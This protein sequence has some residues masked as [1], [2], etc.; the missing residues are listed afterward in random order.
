MLQI[1]SRICNYDADDWDEDAFNALDTTDASLDEWFEYE[2]NG[3]STIKMN[4]AIDPG[5]TV[6]N[7]R[8][9]YPNELHDQIRTA[10]DIANSYRL[11]Q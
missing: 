7:I 1:L 4:A 6:V 5:T 2:L 8:I 3:T 9:D 11:G 10:A